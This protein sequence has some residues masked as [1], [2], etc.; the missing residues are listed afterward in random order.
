MTQRPSTP[1]LYRPQFEH[2]S[3]GVSFVA[4]LKGTPSHQMVQLGLAALCNLEHRGAKGAEVNSGDGAGIL[5]Q[6][7]DRFLREVA[8][9]EGF[10]LPERGAYGCGV[11]FWPHDR[12]ELEAAR[13]GFSAIAESEG[14]SVLGWRQPPVDDSML[15]RGARSAMPNFW[16]VF[17]GGGG[18]RHDELERR[19]YVLRKR[20]EHELSGVYFP[21]LSSR[22]LVYKGMLTAPQLAQFYLDLG[23]PRLESALALVHSRFSTN[24]FPSWP[25]AHPY[26]YLAHNGEINTLQ[27][28]RNWMRSREALLRSDLIPGDLRRIFPVITPGASDSASFD[29]VL[30]LLHLGGRPLP[31][32][33]LMM[34]PEAW[35][36][37]ESMSPQRRAFYQFHAS[38]ME[39]WDGPAS[40][41]FTDGNVIGAVLDRNG[42]RP[43][44]YWV[45]DDGLVI[46]AS[47]VGVLDVDPARVVRKGRL[48]PGRMFLV[49]VGAG[50]IV[51]DD[52]IK[53]Q[54]AS[55]HPY[56]D[57]LAAGLTRLDQL[58]TPRRRSP[59]GSSGDGSG[60]V[61]P[62]GAEPVDPQPLLRRQLLFGYTQEDLRVLMLP[63]AR[64]GV[65]PV[66]SMGSDTPPAV[67]SRR[68]RLLFDY[69]AQLF[70]QVTN[71]PLD[72][73]RE[74]LVTSLSRS[75][76]PEGN[77]LEASPQSCRQL[78]L[79]YPIVDNEELEKLAAAGEHRPWLEAR[80]IY[81][82]YPV[83]GGG[84][85]LREAL[86]EVRRQ[87]SRA[88]AEG[89]GILI[90]SDRHA[91]AQ[92]APIPSLLLTSAVHHHLIREGTRTRVGLVVQAG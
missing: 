21:S 59:N 17:V 50:R 53:D 63:M 27:G 37:H 41:A 8:A 61:A 25:L 13:S 65:E 40:V 92:M 34:I 90:L 32:A 76:G 70:A 39:P 24:T 19:L 35:E 89:A 67:L 15:G 81:A 1:G 57:W 6:I 7:P 2:D 9:E 10:G 58:A 26:R 83:E 36:N 73:I 82:S 71:P 16:Q 33:V 66:G 52:E 91:S 42:L 55:E 69:F 44:R 80:T 45:T 48:Q 64:D 68:P 84:E 88:I 85:A 3:C 43:S 38:L 86:E 72:A 14:L 78:V 22:V 49:D 74:E 56:A 51:N 20:S 62:N 75:L 11:G 28:N 47:E 5:V 60:R 46:M 87:A 18:L 23:D 30:E 79:D 31:H 29:E 54:L 12:R 77:L 4:D